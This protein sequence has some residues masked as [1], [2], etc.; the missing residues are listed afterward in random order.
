M[1]TP[2]D[3]IDSD[4]TGRDE[5]PTRKMIDAGMCALLK[6]DSRFDGLDE[7]VI[8]IWRA[9]KNAAPRI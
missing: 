2:D 6:Y 4:V 3:K 7:A 8:Q 5:E 1:M 9:M